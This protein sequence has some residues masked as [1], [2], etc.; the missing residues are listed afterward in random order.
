MTLYIFHHMLSICML[1]TRASTLCLIM[2]IIWWVRRRRRQRSKSAFMKDSWKRD[3]NTTSL[4]VHRLASSMKFKKTSVKRVC[5]QRNEKKL[6]MKWVFNYFPFLLSFLLVKICVVVIFIV[7]S[8]LCSKHCTRNTTK[9]LCIPS[10]KIY[11]IPQIV[12]RLL[13]G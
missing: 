10:H 7:E 1:F 12:S 9:L 3:H 5:S 6:R 2:I 8:I 4:K 11:C 13:D